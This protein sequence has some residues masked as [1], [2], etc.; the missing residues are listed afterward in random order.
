MGWAYCDFDEM[1]FNGNLVTR[2]FLCVHKVLNPKRT[3]YECVASDLMVLPSASVLRRAAFEQV[4]GF[5]EALSGY[6]D[7]DLFVRFIRL[8]WEHVF[9]FQRPPAL[10]DALRAQSDRHA[11][12]RRG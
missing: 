3:I 12:L 8:G 2:A 10:R 7:D 11:T 4:G 9:G 6:E 1:D 5:D